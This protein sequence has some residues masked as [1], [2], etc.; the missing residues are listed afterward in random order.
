MYVL[1]KYAYSPGFVYKAYTDQKRRWNLLMNCL[2]MEAEKG[3]SILE[4]SIK[5][6]LDFFE[7]YEYL[8]LWKNK[9]LIKFNNL[10]I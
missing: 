3:S 9:K 7:L 8:V 1:Y 6:K 10:N 4:L 2:P 5:Y